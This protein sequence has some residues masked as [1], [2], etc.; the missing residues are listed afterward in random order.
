MNAVAITARQL[1]ILRHA[2]GWT[3]IPA[4]RRAQMTSIEQ[5]QRNAYCANP[6]GVDWADLQA[7]E[8]LGLVRL[9]HTT[10]EGRVGVF[11]LTEEG[12]TVLRDFMER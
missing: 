10:N 12:F 11:H 4:H 1:G 3:E 7:L 2:T 5:L 9:S 8:D 6:D